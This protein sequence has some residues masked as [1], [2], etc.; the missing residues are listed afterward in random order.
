MRTRMGSISGITFTFNTY[1]CLSRPP[2]SSPP[3]AVRPLFTPPRPKPTCGNS[4][5]SRCSVLSLSTQSSSS[6]HTTTF[7]APP[8]PQPP[9]EIPGRQGAPREC[10]HREHSFHSPLSAYRP[11]GLCRPPIATSWLPL[12]L[13]LGTPGPVWRRDRRGCRRRSG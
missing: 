2:R 9:G 8:R 6:P 3:G 10:P 7:L 11:R 4:L 13:G 5:P 1:K 12:G